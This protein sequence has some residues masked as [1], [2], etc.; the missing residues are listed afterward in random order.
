M[1]LTRNLIC[2]IKGHRIV[3]GTFVTYCAR[4]HKVMPRPFEY[5][6]TDLFK[7]APPGPPVPPRQ[8]P[9]RDMRDPLAFP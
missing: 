4:C 6:S 3:R 7:L 9:P 1:E 5:E 2:A 8:D